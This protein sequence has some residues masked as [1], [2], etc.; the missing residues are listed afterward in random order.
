MKHSNCVM[1]MIIAENFDCRFCDRR[2]CDWTVVDD[3]NGDNGDDVKNY[4]EWQWY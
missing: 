3:S 2:F 4:V 1:I